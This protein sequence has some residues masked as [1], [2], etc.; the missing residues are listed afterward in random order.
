MIVI[1]SAL[2]CDAN[3]RGE[4]QIASIALFNIRS[5]FMGERLIAG[6]EAKTEAGR[7]WSYLIRDSLGIRFVEGIFDTSDV[8]VSLSFQMP[9]ICA[10]VAKDRTIISLKREITSVEYCP[11]KSVYPH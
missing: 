8:S 3:L 5:Y 10:V 2:L 1:K 4:K 6:A 7:E 9:L 11:K